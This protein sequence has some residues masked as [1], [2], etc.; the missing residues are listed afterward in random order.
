MFWIIKQFNIA[1]NYYYSQ[2][3]NFVFRYSI[4]PS[5]YV[6]SKESQLVQ[7]YTIVYSDIIYSLI[8]YIS[9]TEMLSHYH[10]FKHETFYFA[11]VKKQVYVSIPL[12]NL[13]SNLIDI[14][15]YQLYI[16]TK[17][18]LETCATHDNE[19]KVT[20]LWNYL[21]VSVWDVKFRLTIC[22]E[23]GMRAVNT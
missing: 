7:Q 11:I 20:K 23:C 9:N 21:Q 18:E 14:Q 12:L 17:T 2:G 13:T 19:D 15:I 5:L 22:R 8:S 10:Y 6:T 16:W 3:K 1:K 4:L